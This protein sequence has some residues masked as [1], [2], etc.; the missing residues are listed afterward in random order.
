MLSYVLCHVRS[1]G[2]CALQGGQAV[3][4]YVGDHPSSVWLVGPFFAAVTGLA[5]KEVRSVVLLSIHVFQLS[6]VGWA[7]AAA[8]HL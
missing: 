2:K 4:Q 7:Q 5:F 3:P 8:V 1:K 6:C